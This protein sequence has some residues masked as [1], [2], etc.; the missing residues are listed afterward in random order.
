MKRPQ[1]TPWNTVGAGFAGSQTGTMRLLV[2][3][4]PWVTAVVDHAQMHEA[5][6]L[7][8]R[9]SG[10]C[11]GSR[12]TWREPVPVVQAHRYRTFHRRGGPRQEHVSRRLVLLVLPVVACPRRSPR[13]RRRDFQKTCDL[14]FAVRHS[15]CRR[16]C[17]FRWPGCARRLPLSWSMML[18][19]TTLL[20]RQ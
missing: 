19:R 8:G 14:V 17:R 6:L 11:K 5:K 16:V 15:R 3:K 1:K 18:L 7:L 13:M 4:P 2:D 9:G 12:A 20:H 10:R